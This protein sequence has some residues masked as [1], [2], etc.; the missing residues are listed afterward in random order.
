M[1]VSISV[2]HC[3]L[4]DHDYPGINRGAALSCHP[5]LNYFQGDIRSYDT[6][7]QAIVL[8]IAHLKEPVDNCRICKEKKQEVDKGHVPMYYHDETQKKQTMRTVPPH[9]VVSQRLSCSTG[10]PW[11]EGSSTSKDENADATAM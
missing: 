1:G 11:F 8:N 5:C 2:F 10:R 4:I 7:Q 9:T 3:G 6:T